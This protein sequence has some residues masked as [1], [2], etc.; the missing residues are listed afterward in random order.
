MQSLKQPNKQTNE[1]TNKGAED[2]V[3]KQLTGVK[4]VSN[5]Y[6]LQ[7]PD[8][9]LTGIGGWREFD[10][11]GA[12]VALTRGGCGASRGALARVRGGGDWVDGGASVW[13][14]V[15]V[16]VRREARRHR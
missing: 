8:R 6:G 7:G 14:E 2:R 4:K 16:Q 1:Q 5:K 15:P 11:A 12:A 13:R 10:A 3:L 9:A